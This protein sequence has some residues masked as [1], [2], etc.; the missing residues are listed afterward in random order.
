MNQYNSYVKIN[1]KEADLVVP[2]F[3]AFYEKIRRL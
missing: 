2:V 1:S 3:S